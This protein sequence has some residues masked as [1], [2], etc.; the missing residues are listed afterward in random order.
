MRGSTTGGWT[1]GLEYNYKRLLNN[2]N[3]KHII[4]ILFNITIINYYNYKR[5]I[6]IIFKIVLLRYNNREARKPVAGP[7]AKINNK[8]W[9]RKYKET[10]MYIYIYIERER[11]I[12]ERYPVNRTIIKIGLRGSTTG[13]WTSGQNK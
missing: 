6:H 11:E 10:C 12:I 5:I 13:G 1:S 9:T 2:Y 7:P 3:Y 4:N 8:K